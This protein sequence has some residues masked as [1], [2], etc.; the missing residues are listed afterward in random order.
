MAGP[1]PGFGQPEEPKKKA[2]GWKLGPEKVLS[3]KQKKDIRKAF[4]MFDTDASGTIPKH[5]MN[6]IFKALGLD[7]GQSEIDN[8]IEEMDAINI[9]SLSMSAT[10][11]MDF[12]DFQALIVRKMLE[13]EPKFE[14]MK[15]FQYFDRDN[16]GVITFKDLKEVSQELGE[17]MTDE[18][19][20][21]MIDEAD[22]L[23]IGAVAPQDYWLAMKGQRMDVE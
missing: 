9:Q 4:D 12:N 10:G 7:L 15:L 23:G 18:E 13:D 6:I 11:I 22:T 8:M 17:S 20:Q 1:N 21:E 5:R 14:V 16:T 2:T 19:I 3:K